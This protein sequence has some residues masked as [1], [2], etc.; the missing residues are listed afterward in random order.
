MQVLNLKGKLGGIL[1][2]LAAQAILEF[3]MVVMGDIAEFISTVM[4]HYF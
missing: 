2:L 3:N 4:Q 1:Y